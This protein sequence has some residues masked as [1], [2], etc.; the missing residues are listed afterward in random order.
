MSQEEEL[1]END[2]IFNDWGST[3]EVENTVQEIII[4]AL[5]GLQH[6]LPIPAT[7]A[8]ATAATAATATATISTSQQSPTTHFSGRIRRREEVIISPE[9]YKLF[10]GT[11]GKRIIRHRCPLYSY[12]RL[13]SGDEF[14]FTEDDG[15]NILLNEFL[16]PNRLIRNIISKV[17]IRI[18]ERLDYLG[19]FKH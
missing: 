15:K 6:P 11:Q 3:E 8:T 13:K 14:H 16:E 18:A 5:L 12:L 9:S 10:R 7:A 1:D 2:D 19:K 17:P 4:Q